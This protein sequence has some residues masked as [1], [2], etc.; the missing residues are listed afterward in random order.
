MNVTVKIGIKKA[1]CELAADIQHDIVQKFITEMANDYDQI[2]VGDL[3]MKRMQIVQRLAEV[4]VWLSQTGFRFI[5]TTGT[6]KDY[7]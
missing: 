2:A 4:V 7:F 5:N 6:S 1:L 3:V